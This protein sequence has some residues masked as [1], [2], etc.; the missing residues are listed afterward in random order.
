[1]TL[2]CLEAIQEYAF[3]INTFAIHYIS[4]KLRRRYQGLLDK[5]SYISLHS[6]LT[7]PGV[8][9]YGKVVNGWRLGGTQNRVNKYSHKI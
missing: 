2:L 1:M 4:L 6:L 9:L 3:M 8:Q 5:V 7:L